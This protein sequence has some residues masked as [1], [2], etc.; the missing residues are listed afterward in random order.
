MFHLEAEKNSLQQR[1][2]SILA[3]IFEFLSFIL[4]GLE[5]RCYT[6]ALASRCAPGRFA[7]SLLLQ[8]HWQ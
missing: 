6:V 7:R 4:L 5:I 2:N 8:W 3:F 1:D